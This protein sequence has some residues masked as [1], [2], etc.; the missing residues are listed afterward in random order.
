[1]IYVGKKIYIFGQIKI[2]I[3]VVKARKY[4]THPNHT[5]KRYKCSSRTQRCSSSCI[6]VFVLLYVDV[7]V[8]VQKEA[9]TFC[10]LLLLKYS[11]RISISISIVDYA[12]LSPSLVTFGV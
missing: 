10:L 12:L 7:N 5:N 6:S 1:M 2:L 3:S 9:R 8:E 4:T 11:T